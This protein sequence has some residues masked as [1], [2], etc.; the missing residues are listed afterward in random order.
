MCLP[1]IHNPFHGTT[2]HQDHSYG[3]E[4]GRGDVVD[5][6]GEALICLGSIV[7]FFDF[8]EIKTYGSNIFLVLLLESAS[9]YLPISVWKRR[10]DEA[11][12]GYA[13]NHLPL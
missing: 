13:T 3:R 2:F 9:G 8:S 7:D 1:S 12:D 10:L 11:L 4:M 5:K 6:R